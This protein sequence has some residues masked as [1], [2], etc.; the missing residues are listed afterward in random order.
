MRQIVPAT[1][2]DPL[3]RSKCLPMTHRPRPF[4]A[5]WEF[6]HIKVVAPANREEHARL[7]AQKC[8][9]DAAK[10]GINRWA[11]EIVA[12]GDLISSMIQALNEAEFRQMCAIS[13]PDRQGD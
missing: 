3:L 5:Q 4:L 7:L 1:S 6:E 11:L 13:G 9:D 2:H 12:G 10:V 8:R